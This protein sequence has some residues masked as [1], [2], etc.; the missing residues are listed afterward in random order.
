MFCFVDLYS[1]FFFIINFVF[2]LLTIVDIQRGIDLV[3][4]K[5]SL[6]TLFDCFPYLRSLKLGSGAW[7]EMEALFCAR[8]LEGGHLLDAV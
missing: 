1:D 6:G 2:F 4:S 5:L 7:S 8:G 3:A